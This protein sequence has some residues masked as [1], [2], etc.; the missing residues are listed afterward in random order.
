MLVLVCGD[1]NWNNRPAIVRELEKLN[2]REDSILHGGASG[3]DALADEV[4]RSLGFSVK[5][6]YAQW[7]TYGRAA[8]PIRNQAM[9]D[10]NPSLVLAFHPNLPVS[11]GT[12]DMVRR[13][14]GKGVEVRVFAE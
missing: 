1:R 12:G 5:V 8:G 3:A 2:P 13:A 10:L 9:L 14:R 11:K 6:L 7:H 4:G